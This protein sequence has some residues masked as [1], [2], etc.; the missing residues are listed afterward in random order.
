VFASSIGD[1]T[2]GDESGYYELW[3]K[4]N[5][6]LDG[7]EVYAVYSEDGGEDFDYAIWCD[8]DGENWV[9]LMEARSLGT[10]IPY[11]FEVYDSEGEVYTL[12]ENAPDETFTVTVAENKPG[13]L[14]GDWRV[15]IFDLLDLLGYLGQPDDTGLRDL[16][17]DGK[18]DIFDLLELLKLM[19]R[20]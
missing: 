16:N 7:P 10:V 15:S 11:Y 20:D 2:F 1:E 5:D 6:V 8:F 13:D 9:A 19:A 3:V 12:P 4:I 14:D 17:A 18:V